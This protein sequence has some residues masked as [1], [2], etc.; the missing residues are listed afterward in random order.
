MSVK[1]HPS[2]IVPLKPAGHVS[3][4]Q[5]VP[6]L[7][8]SSPLGQVRQVIAGRPHPALTGLQEGV[9][10]VAQVSGVQQLPS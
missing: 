10:T 3:G 6:S 8:H 7:V 2:S 9:F 1:P 5:Q 4:W